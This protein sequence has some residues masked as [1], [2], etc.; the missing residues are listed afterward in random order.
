MPASWIYIPL[1]LLK[2]KHPYRIIGFSEPHGRI[3][4]TL[5]DHGEPREIKT[6]L[7]H[8]FLPPF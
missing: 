4:L 2:E 3:M 5:K 6:L 1:I 7:A 8:V